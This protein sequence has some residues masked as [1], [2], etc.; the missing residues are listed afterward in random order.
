MNIP[1]VIT[2]QE[3]IER[4]DHPINA[5]VAFYQAFNARNAEVAANNWSRKYSI[6]MSNPIGGIRRNW[7][8]IREGYGKIMEG[9]ARVYVEY[10]DFNFH[11]FDNVFYVEGRERGSIVTN[12]LELGLKVRTTRI[13]KL[14]DEGWKQVH[15][16][17]SIDNPELQQRY[18]QAI[19]KLAKED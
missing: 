11:L 2:G 17:G 19:F 12:D 7:N 18:Q 1:K 15:H 9:E 13:Y 5:L 6:A 14:F 10:H 16:H 8:A 3:V 4:P